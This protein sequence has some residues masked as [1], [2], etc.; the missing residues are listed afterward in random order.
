MEDTNDTELITAQEAKKLFS[1]AGL[2]NATFYR[3]VQSKQID[4][5]LP[6]GRQ[7]GAKYKKSQVL[8]ALG[9]HSITPSVFT[10]ATIEDMPE[11]AVLLESFYHVKI[12]VE[13]RG[14]WIKRNPKVTYI[15]RNNG[16][17]IG[18]GTIMPLPEEK[19]L[20]IL[21]TQVKPPTLPHEIPL[22]EP[23][24]H[25]SLY[26][27]ACGVLQ[28]TDKRQRRHWAARLITGLVKAVIEL[29]E[30]G[31]HIDRI[32]AQGDTKAGEKALKM[33]GFAQIEL[34]VATNRKNYMLDTEKSGSVFAAR[35]RAALDEWREKNID[36]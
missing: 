24:E 32:Y 8:A 2:S 5:I 1:Q 9:K 33:L 3:Y 16:Q 36:E 27:R 10:Q 34:Y 14:A 35:Y 4:S 26:V 23:G 20:Q 11:I 17:L 13:K 19:I 12:S 28:E 21:T 7:R 25:Y 31:I 15:L 6:E 22:Y 18:C 29:G 30:M